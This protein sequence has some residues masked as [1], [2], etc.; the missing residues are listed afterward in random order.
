MGRSF[1]LRRRGA[2]E[3]EVY[4]D[5]AEIRV[6]LD[7]YSRRVVSGEWRDYALDHDG[8]RAVFSVFR[9]SLALPHCTVEKLARGAG[10]RLWL[11]GQGRIEAQNI[12][13]VLAALDAGPRLIARNN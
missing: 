4:F 8:G 7:L 5:R 11:R 2:G 6:L 10:F 12:A 1:P 13:E 9:H 3:A